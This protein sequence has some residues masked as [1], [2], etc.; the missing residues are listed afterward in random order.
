MGKWRRGGRTPSC[1]LFS[2][3]EAVRIPMMA[4]DSKG[5]SIAMLHNSRKLLRRGVCAQNFV[6]HCADCADDRCKT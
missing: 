6:C 5:I 2:L 1:G 3:C 4:P